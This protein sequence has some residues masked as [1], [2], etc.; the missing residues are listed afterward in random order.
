[1]RL[2]SFRATRGSSIGGLST[3]RS[4]AW[5]KG[6]KSSEAHTPIAAPFDFLCYIDETTAPD[7]LPWTPWEALQK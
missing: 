6:I 2:I 4:V 1:M 7:M 3:L 5:K